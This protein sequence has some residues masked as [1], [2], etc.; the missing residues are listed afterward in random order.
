M[1]PDTININI[2]C[3]TDLPSIIDPFTLNK[4]LKEMFILVE[5]PIKYV[6]LMILLLVNTYTVSSIK[7][8]P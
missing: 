1:K 6:C 2:S 3:I 7:M 8:T 5:M 4:Y